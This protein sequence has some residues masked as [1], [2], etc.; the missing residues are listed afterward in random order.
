MRARGLEPPRAFA[1][2]VL[3]P[4]RL[5]IPP[6]PRG[7]RQASAAFGAAG[8]L[9]A[10]VA[11]SKD[12]GAASPRAFD[13]R[14]AFAFVRHQVSLGPRPAGSAAS[15]RLAATLRA[16]VPNGRYQSVPGGLR[17]VIGVVRGRNPRR[18]VVVGAHY[19]TKEIPNFVGAN[20]GAS[21]TA[22][23]LQISRTIR[24]RELRPTVVFIFFDGEETPANAPN[25]DFL[26]HGLRGSKIAARTYRHAEAM[27]LLDLVGDR[28]L[29]LPREEGSNRRLWAQLRAAARRKGKL[30]AFPNRTQGRVFDDHIPFLQAGVPAID[31]IDFEFP[32]WHR[33]CDDMSA[34]SARSLDAVGESVLELL[35][36]L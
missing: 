15:R 17:N 18:V 6:H 13:E 14:A 5:P 32:C 20:D 34:V 26:S 16:R 9:L 10:L 23:V 21:G 22:A 29:S 33:T 25:D 2:R 28:Q 7:L 3:N 24:P 8:L 11:V 30:W 12:A 27:I 35:R 4:P 19:D 1:Q 31:L 36:S